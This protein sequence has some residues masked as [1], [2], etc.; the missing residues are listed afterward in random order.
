MFLQ[1]IIFSCCCSQLSPAITHL[2]LTKGFTF[3]ITIA[4]VSIKPTDK[5]LK[6]I[7]KERQSYLKEVQNQLIDE[8]LIEIS[9][10]LKKIN[11]LRDN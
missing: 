3:I 9:G 5:Q 1:A 10:S 4:L 7:V 2:T 8:K 11:L 6:V